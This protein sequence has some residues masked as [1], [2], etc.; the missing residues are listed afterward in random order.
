MDRA[1]YERQ[2]AF[3]EIAV[4]GQEKLARGSALIVGCGALGTTVAVLLARMGVGRLVLVDRD[5]VAFSNLPR[6][7]LFDEEDARTCLPKVEAARRKLAAINSE[8][9]IDAHAAHLGRDNIADLA[10]GVDIIL[11]GM[12]NFDTR[13]LVNDYSIASS[14]PWIY[15]AVLGATGLSMNVLPGETPCLRCLFREPPGP[16]AP[17]TETEGVI[18][19]VIR[20]IGAVEAAEAAKLLLGRRAEMSR[21]LTSVDLWRSEFRSM[22]ISLVRED[23]DCP[24]CM[25]GRF[26]WLRGDRGV[27]R[28][29][30]S[31]GTVVHLEGPGRPVDLNALARRLPADGVTA[32]PFLVRF[33][34]HP[35]VLTIFADGRAIVEGT[36]DL[37][38]AQKLYDECVLQRGDP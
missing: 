6:Q 2:I 8:L 22:D 9:K 14:T 4:E 29:V 28:A 20:V 3:R 25:H 11:D 1:R 26:D 38:L 15:A 21:K 17:T 5:F 31:A 27:A 19:P 13:M 34:R 10:R 18:A 37:A 36:G 33:E 12:D 24:V 35:Y 16:D 30:R 23:S 32:N 7:A